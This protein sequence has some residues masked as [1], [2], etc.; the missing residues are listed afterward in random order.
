MTGSPSRAA[1]SHSQLA[2]CRLDH[3]IV[4][5]H[6]NLAAQ[7]I[8]QNRRPMI[9]ADP[10][11]QTQAVAERPVADT[12]LIPWA[13]GRPLF[14]QNETVGVLATPQSLDDRR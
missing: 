1:R 4:E 14:E 9:A 13:K 11:I 12:Y 5:Y 6:A 2:S 10:F 3:L 8:K 7:Q